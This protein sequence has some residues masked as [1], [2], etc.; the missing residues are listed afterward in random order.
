MSAL[1]SSFDDK[2][3][4]MNFKPAV[5]DKK[6]RIDDPRRVDFSD[7]SQQFGNDGNWNQ[8]MNQNTIEI[9]REDLLRRG[10]ALDFENENIKKYKKVKF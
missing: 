6:E 9:E 8:M 4:E 5:F 10:D 3:Y 1:K 2:K 7:F